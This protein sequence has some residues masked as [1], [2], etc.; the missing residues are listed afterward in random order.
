M[1][2]DTQSVWGTWT[3]ME[4]VRARFRHTQA[5]AG[6]FRHTRTHKVHLPVHSSSR[7]RY[8]RSP[9]SRLLLL[10]TQGHYWL[11]CLCP[12]IT[13]SEAPPPSLHVQM[14]TFGRRDVTRAG[15]RSTNSL[16]TDK[17]IRTHVKIADKPHFRGSP[18]ISVNLNLPERKK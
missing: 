14:W 13:S 3:E 1:N 17:P 12:S 5:H 4:A 18:R 9:L 11:R 16:I 7:S 10:F 2:S 8:I 6:T 15:L